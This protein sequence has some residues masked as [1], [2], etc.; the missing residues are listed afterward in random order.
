MIAKKFSKFGPLTVS[1][2]ARTFILHSP[3]QLLNA[4][5]PCSRSK[6]GLHQVT[7]WIVQGASEPQETNANQAN[8]KKHISCPDVVQ[9]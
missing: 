4:E 3:D 6:Y 2:P 1:L 9:V 5:E 7:R 8:K